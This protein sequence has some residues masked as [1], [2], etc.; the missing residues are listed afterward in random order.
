MNAPR[1]SLFLATLLF[2]VPAHAATPAL[3]D[4]S[5]VG[6]VHLPISCAPKL[7]AEFD[8][9]VA[10]LHSF[11]YEEARNGFTKIAEQDPKCAMAQWGIA[12]TLWHPIWTP[13][14]DSELKDG[15]AAV[16]KAK[17]LGGKTELEKGFI[18]AIAAYYEVAEASKA[19]GPAGQT[20]H[21]PVA[22]DYH[23]RAVAYEKKM[24][25]LFQHHPEET[26]VATFYSLALLGSAVPTDK[27]L[28]NQSKATSIL[29]KMYGKKQNHPGIA[30]YLIHGYDYPPVAEK[31]LP[32]AKGYAQIAP[33]VPHALHMPSH[34]FTRLGMWKESIDSNQA[35]ADASKQ[36]AAEKHPGAISFEEVH[37]LD[38][39]AYANLQLGRD[40]EAKKALD[41]LLGAKKTY[42]EIDFVAA[43]AFGTLPARYAV[44]RKQ[45]KDA[46][47]LVTPK[48]ASFSKFQFAEA[49][50]EFGRA[51]GNAKT[52][53]L[54][55]AKAAAARIKALADQV[56]EPKFQYFV[57]QARV[58]EQVALA[59]IAG[60]EGKKAEA[61]AMLR[62]AADED[63]TLG[64]H[65]VSPG[66]ILP[67]REVLA[68]YLLENGRGDDALKEFEAV[69]KISPRRFNTLYGAAQAAALAKKPDIAKKHYGELVAM[70]EG[71][72]R[73]EI[74]A[75]K[76][77]LAAK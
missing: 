33:W 70:A 43:Y 23:A 24:A 62:K 13:P 31:G 35:S 17:A 65:P 40:A 44:E 67:A 36:Y 39:L 16:A 3:G 55:E 37:A 18:S 49:T 53:K 25:E 5:K 54:A 28:A 8:R 75:A 47:A 10:L 22:S 60:A 69:M 66:P 12:M 9:S 50:I 26:E 1:S 29:E 57:T 4:L 48:S 58:Q 15:L 56:K 68:E 46:A 51:L 14:N 77:F 6:T 74:A 61:E 2:A 42:P 21:G 7:Q 71:G 73:S 76:S 30:H 59:L 32:A 11:F 52:G 19:Q 64:K 38:Y 72:S 41:R 34:I 63:D 27:T 45:W 20:C